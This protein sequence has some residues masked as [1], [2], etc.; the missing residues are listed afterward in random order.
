[1]SRPIAEKGLRN[2]TW[3]GRMEI[4][5]QDPLVLV[6][7]AHNPYS[8]RVLREALEEWFPGR[9]W[10]LVFGASAD[11]DIEGMLRELQPIADHVIVTRS[12]H[13]R[14]A[15]PTKLADIAAS[16]GSGAEINVNVTRSLQRALAMMEPDNGL[17]FTGS[18]FLVTDARDAWAAHNGHP[19]PEND[20]A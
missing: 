18:I 19:L 17:L 5:S 11:K 9:R 14:A 15:A 3:P 12:E 6:D 7:C 2:V 16:V 8:T 20:R 13:P 4:L 10:V 1:M